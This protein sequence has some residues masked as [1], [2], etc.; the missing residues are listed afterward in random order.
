MIPFKPVIWAQDPFN[1][2]E[3]DHSTIH[4]LLID[5]QDTQPR[6]RAELAVAE[7]PQLRQHLCADTSEEVTMQNMQSWKTL[8]AS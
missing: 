5:V 8:G 4:H 7:T 1:L 2:S 6:Y 3:A